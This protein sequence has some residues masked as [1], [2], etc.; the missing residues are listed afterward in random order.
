MPRI[1]KRLCYLCYLDG[2]FVDA[3]GS[4]S[5][6]PVDVYDVCEKH[7][8]IAEVHDLVTWKFT[9]DENIVEA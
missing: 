7:M 8:K 1:Y 3:V 9:E 2:E 4:Y 5:I 6:E